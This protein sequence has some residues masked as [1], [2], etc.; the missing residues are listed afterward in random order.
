MELKHELKKWILLVN[1]T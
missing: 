1:I